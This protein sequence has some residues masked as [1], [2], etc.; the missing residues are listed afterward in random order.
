[1]ALQHLRHGL[2][3]LARAEAVDEPDLLAVGEG[4]VVE[5]LVHALAGLLDGEADQVDFRGD[6]FR[7]KGD[8][9]GGSLGAAPHR[10]AS[11]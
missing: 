5:E 10:S 1:M 4:R 7:G 11:G 6:G 8:H 2:P 3:E 9:A